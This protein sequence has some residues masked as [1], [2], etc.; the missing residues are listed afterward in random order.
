MAH[1]IHDT[2]HTSLFVCGIGMG[3]GAGG[4]G[5]CIAAGFI[6]SDGGRDGAGKE[7]IGSAATTTTD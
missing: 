1:L 5:G 2:R 4:S 6:G 7:G 3:S